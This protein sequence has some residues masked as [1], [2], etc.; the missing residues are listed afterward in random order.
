LGLWNPPVMVA[1]ERIKS[2]EFGVPGSEKKVWGFGFRVLESS[3]MSRFLPGNRVAAGSSG[4]LH[5]KFDDKIRIFTGDFGLIV[6]RDRI[7]TGWKSGVT[8]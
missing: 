4:V 8:A 2:S 1:A 6:A 3:A 5:C 7:A